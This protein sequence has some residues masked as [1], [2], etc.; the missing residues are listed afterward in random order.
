MSAR[1]LVADHLI[2]DAKALEARL[3][4]EYFEVIVA[5][6]GA[7]ALEVCLRRQCDV[8]LLEVSAPEMRAFEVCRQIKSDSRIGHM[9]V[10]MM[11]TREAQ[12][13]RL[14]GLEAGADEFLIKPINEIA[15]LARVRSL[16]RLK[17]L[18][19]ELML[20][21]TTDADLGIDSQAHA[22]TDSGLGARIL[23]VDDSIETTQKVREALY[24]H[25]VKVEIEPQ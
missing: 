22:T 1:I 5:T 8:V 25:S 18:M 13:E 12:S 24:E 16:V 2:A 23:L 17:T 14:K 6:N 9:P 4:E 10:V 20:R 11:T 15:L 21:S 19:D 7:E 3:A